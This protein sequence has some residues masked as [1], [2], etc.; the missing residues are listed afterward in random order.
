MGLKPAHHSEEC[1]AK[2]V[3]HMTAH[4]D[5][6]Q[7]VQIAQHR[8][9]KQH[10]LMRELKK[11]VLCQNLYERKS[12][13][14]NEWKNKH[15]SVLWIQ[16]HRAAAVPVPVPAAV[17]PR[18]PHRCWLMRVMR[19]VQ[20]RQNVTHGTEMELEE[21]VMESELDRLQRYTDCCFLVQVQDADAHLDKIVF[22]K[23]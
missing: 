7:R 19:T 14:Q 3:R 22:S 23:A 12:D 2:I 17:R 8:L 21:L 20:K 10:R 13:S 18:L 15:P 6:N 5:L 4:D 11:E 9:S 16:I 1:R